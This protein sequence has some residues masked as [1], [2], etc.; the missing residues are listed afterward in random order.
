MST[1]SRSTQDEQMKESLKVPR[2]TD[3][4]KAKT[5]EVLPD[6]RTSKSSSRPTEV[7]QDETD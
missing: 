4:D 2:Y 3:A 5:F 6:S 1:S 7:L